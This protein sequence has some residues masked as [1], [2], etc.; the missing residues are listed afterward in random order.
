MHWQEAC[1]KSEDKKARRET[2]DG[3]VMIV[4]I[5]GDCVI[6]SR[7]GGYFEKCL[8]EKWFGYLDWESE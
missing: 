8:P 6:S 5:C 3:R 4:H 2:K 1:L 7:K